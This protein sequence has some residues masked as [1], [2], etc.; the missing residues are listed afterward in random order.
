METPW[1]SLTRSNSNVTR[2]RTHVTTIIGG[3]I[4]RDVAS[5]YINNRICGVGWLTSA[6]L[7]SPIVLHLLMLRTL[8]IY[9][10]PKKH[11]ASQISQFGT[12]KSEHKTERHREDVPVVERQSDVFQTLPTNYRAVRL[13]CCAKF[14]VFLF[15]FF[16]FFVEK[17]HS[18]SCASGMLDRR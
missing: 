16:S 17:L 11:H 5:L 4:A 1:A 3:P 18:G 2:G 13:N 8:S 10:V 9:H 12:K 15:F 7:Q 6:K 14:F